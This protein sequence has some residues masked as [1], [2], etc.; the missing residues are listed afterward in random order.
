MRASEVM[1][2]PTEITRYLSLRVM[3]DA[4]PVLLVGLV[5]EGDIRRDVGA[6][7]VQPQGVGPPRVVDGRVQDAGAV[8]SELRAGEGAGD[9]VG[10]AAR[11]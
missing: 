4:E 7:G 6:D 3:P 9:L 10:E 8:G 2:E 11:R 5:E 1:L